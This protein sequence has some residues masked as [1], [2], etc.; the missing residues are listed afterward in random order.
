[1]QKI[2]LIAAAVVLVAVPAFAKRDCPPKRERPPMSKAHSD[3]NDALDIQK[4]QLEN[5][6]EMNYQ[7]FEMLEEGRK[8]TRDAERNKRR[9]QREKD[10][11]RNFL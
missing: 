8:Q 2:F 10:R 3:I 5:Q 9:R 7:V 4:K 11:K 1:M 6:R